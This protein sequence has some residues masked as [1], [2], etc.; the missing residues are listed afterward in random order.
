MKIFKKK[1]KSITKL[2]RVKD[3]GTIDHIT[4]ENGVIRIVVNYKE[5]F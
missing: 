4:Q 5:T 1:L 2:M 3:A